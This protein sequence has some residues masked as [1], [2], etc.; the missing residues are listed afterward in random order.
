M[1]WTEEDEERLQELQ[2][3]KQRHVNLMRDCVVRSV[4]MWYH[5]CLSTAEVADRLIN[6]A[7]AI[8]AVL[9]PFDGGFL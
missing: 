8:R 1:N 2:E 3:R 6:N 9:E 7:T 4:S 5:D